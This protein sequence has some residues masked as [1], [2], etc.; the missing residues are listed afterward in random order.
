MPFESLL[1]ISSMPDPTDFTGRDNGIESFS[2]ID[3]QAFYYF[4]CRRM[5]I[6]CF[7]QPNVS[8]MGH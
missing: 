6:N 7:H 2:R 4:Q 8:Y 1:L 3:R 5:K